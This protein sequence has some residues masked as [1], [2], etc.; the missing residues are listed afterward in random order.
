[1]Y[2][3][4]CSRIKGYNRLLKITRHC[5]TIWFLGM[6]T[7]RFHIRFIRIDTIHVYDTKA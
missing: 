7:Y 1:M 6:P 5:K 2:C 3:W 4:L